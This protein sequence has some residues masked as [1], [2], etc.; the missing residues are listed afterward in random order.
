MFIAVALMMVL[1]STPALAVLDLV[2]FEECSQGSRTSGECVAV[3]SEVTDSGVSLGAT[4]TSP[5]STGTSGSSGSS[6]GQSSDSSPTL[7]GPPTVWTPPPRRDPVLGSA[8]CTVIIQGS[9][10]GSSPPKNP[11]VTDP[12]T[13]VWTAPTA[14]TPPTSISDLAAFQPA[15][16]TIQI[17]PGWWS[18]PRVPTNMYST[19][20]VD[21][22][23]GELL[24]WP[25]QVRFTPQAYR[26]SFGDGSFARRSSSGGS[27][28]SAQFSPTSTSHTYPAPGLYSLGLTIEYSVSYRFEGGAFVDLPGV[29]TKSVGSAN[30]Q[31]LRVSPVLANQGCVVSDLRKGRCP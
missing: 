13:S 16:S 17:E 9:C 22:Q 20:G 4:V 11:P 2:P 15:G 7:A 28:G 25:I 26:W 30:L 8:T 19:A 6:S 29:V 12:D 31:V 10:R 23:A 3:T 24:G 5:G 21:I 27:W 18:L 14:P 1:S